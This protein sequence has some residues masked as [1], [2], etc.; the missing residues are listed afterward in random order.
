MAQSL[1]KT[2]S[3]SQPILYYLF[4]QVN[5]SNSQ[6]RK[7]KIIYFLWGSSFLVIVSV[8]T[9]KLQGYIPIP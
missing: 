3:V 5:F 2:F 1:G 6:K 4:T 9:Y 7:E 8:A